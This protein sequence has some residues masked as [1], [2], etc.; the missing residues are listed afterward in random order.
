MYLLI[1]KRSYSNSQTHTYFSSVCFSLHPTTTEQSVISPLYSPD[2]H[3]VGH[4]P[5]Y[6]GYNSKGPC[7]KFTFLYGPTD[8]N[9]IKLIHIGWWTIL[10]K[11][12]EECK[13][14]SKCWRVEEGRSFF[15][16]TLESLKDEVR[17]QAI[18]IQGKETSRQRR[19]WCQGSQVKFAWCVCGTERM[20]AWHRPGKRR[21]VWGWGRRAYGSGSMAA[22]RALWTVL[23][24]LAVT[25]FQSFPTCSD[26][27]FK[28]VS[29]TFRREKQWQRWK[30][31]GYFNSSANGKFWI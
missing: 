22:H 21:D 23:K 26:L 17:E 16:K 12:T 29:L 5:K 4:F 1:H 8:K 7:P 9:Q 3:G 2:F 25:Q 28:K 19:V 24:T 10:C 27:C 15:N 18:R 11:K 20:A 13:C 30:Q 31:S 14:N 6:W